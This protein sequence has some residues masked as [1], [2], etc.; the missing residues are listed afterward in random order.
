MELWK[1]AAFEQNKPRFV[2]YRWSIRNGS[3]YGVIN[4]NSRADPRRL[5]DLQRKPLE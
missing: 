4:T 5:Y 1:A 2:G 3:I